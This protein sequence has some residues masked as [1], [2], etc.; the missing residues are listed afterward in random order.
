M[1]ALFVLP[2]NIYRE[3]ML[4]LL[5]APN[6]MAVGSMASDPFSEP[7]PWKAAALEVVAESTGVAWPAFGDWSAVMVSERMLDAPA[8]LSRLQPSFAQTL[9]VVVVGVGPLAGRWWGWIS[10]RGQ[11]HPLD[12]FRIVGPSML[13]LER[14]PI[15]KAVDER[16]SR[17][18]GPVGGERVFRVLADASVLVL[19]CSRTGTLA[20]TM[21]AALGVRRLALVDPDVIE[22]HN[23]DGMVLTTPRAVGKPKAV[24]LAKRLSAFRPEMLVQ[25]VKAGLNDRRASRLAGSSQLIVSCVDNGAG[26]L[27][28]ADWAKKAMAVHLDVGSGI[29]M[30]DNRR[31]LAADVRLLLPGRGMGCLRCVGGVARL[32][33]AEAARR[34][35]PHALPRR[36][37]PWNA[38][39]RL[40]SLI[41]LNAAAV[42]SGIQSWLDLLAGELPAS[43]WHRLRWQPRSGWECA[44]ALVTGISGCS[45]CGHPP[46]NAA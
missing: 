2:E 41:T 32:A 13:R 5:K 35:P 6:R 37:E 20:A 38:H 34:L 39:G 22:P 24:A 30:V 7:R 17:L 45:G 1:N 36:H 23:L 33:E 43:I 25:A 29:R 44:T 28:A 14:A 31:E 42:A 11:T 16:W 21:L 46:A 10:T 26:R 8:V 12:G 15:A 40:G 18:V 3:A 9:I 4:E 27:Q 19:G